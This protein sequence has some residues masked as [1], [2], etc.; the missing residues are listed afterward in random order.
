MDFHLLFVEDELRGVQ[1][2]FR[3]LEKVGFLCYFAESGDQA[4][5]KLQ[6]LH[7]DAISMDIMFTPG[8]QMGARV[9]ATEAGLHLLKMI[10]QKKIRNCPADIPVIILTAANDIDIEKAIKIESVTAY[11]RKPMEFAQVIE[12]LMAL[13]KSTV[14]LQH[15]E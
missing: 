7:I 4:I 15:G 11:L 2:Y 13:K 8:P 9:P 6:S 14:G 10:R 5:R 3:E 1:P 12:T